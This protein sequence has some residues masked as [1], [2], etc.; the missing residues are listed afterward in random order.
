MRRGTVIL[1]GTIIAM[2]LAIPAMGGGMEIPGVGAKA[3]AMGGAWRAIANDWSAAYYNPAGLV[4]VT[5]D[6]F[7]VNEA[8]TNFRYKYNPNVK[9]GNYTVGYF[10][11]E[12]TNR[13]AVLTNPSAGGYFRIP[14]SGKTYHFGLAIFQPFDKNISWKLFQPL[15][16]SQELPDKQIEHNFDAVAFNVTAAIEL[17]PNKLSIGISTGV[18]RGDLIYGGFFLRPNPASTTAIYYDQIA[19]R[20]NDLLTEWQRSDGKGW[21]F[22]L[23]AGLMYKATPKLTF[24]FSG[25]I[26][27]QVTVKGDTYLMYYMPDLQEYHSRSDVSSSISAENYILS[28]GAVYAAHAQFKTKINL[29]GQIGGGVAY[30][31]NDKLTL[32][33]DLQYT[34]WSAFKGYEFQYTFASS[35]ITLNNGIN[36]WMTQN[37]SLPVDWKNTLRIGVGA[38]YS[39][40]DII[41]LRGGYAA[42]QSPVKSNTQNPAFFDS[43]LSHSLNLGLGLVFANSITIDLSTEYVINGKTTDSGVTYLTSDGGTD[44]IADNMAGTY[45]GSAWESIAQI[46][47]RF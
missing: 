6:Q 46:T 11:G 3:K 9:Y 2:S 26:P 19:S 31:V 4:Y 12:I 35:A 14:I 15:N 5:E 16:N 43:G 34:L 13:F 39:Y 40:S 27:S 28:S 17:Q 10:N 32:A 41:K 44:N 23:R 7:T 1:L 21:G 18:L 25:A 38:E 36:Q 47:V 29:P 24:G 30:L 33:G 37:M 22:N 42:D 20:P 45:S 8:I